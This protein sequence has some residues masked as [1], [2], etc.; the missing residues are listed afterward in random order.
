[1]RSVYNQSTN[2]NRDER[3]VGIRMDEGYAVYAAGVVLVGLRGDTTV[4]ADIPAARVACTVCAVVAGVVPGAVVAE[5]CPLNQ[6]R[7]SR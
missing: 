2:R 4:A 5:V 3:Y 6:R 7:G 1:M